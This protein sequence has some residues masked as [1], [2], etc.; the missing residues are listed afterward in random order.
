MIRQ[1]VFL[2]LIMSAQTSIAQWGTDFRILH[3]QSLRIDLKNAQAGEEF[4]FT[5][6]VGFGVYYALPER[7]VKG[8]PMVRSF[9]VQLEQLNRTTDFNGRINRSSWVRLPIN[10]SSDIPVRINEG[11]KQIGFISSY[12]GL[13]LSRP[14]AIEQN[15][16]QILQTDYTNIGYQ[17]GL[18][19]QIMGPF[20]MRVKL[21]YN[22]A[23]DAFTMGA[24]D[25]ASWS[26]QKFM[27]QGFSIGM[28]RSFTGTKEQRAAMKEAKAAKKKRKKS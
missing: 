22:L 17:A 5:Q 8:I 11:S 21:M 14:L 2:V 16:S 6:G 7:N 13:N 9:G 10:Y 12:F 28:Q 26:K 4:K 1:F 23:F 27:D 24:K 20:D 15:L 25:A 19:F 3:L 18:G